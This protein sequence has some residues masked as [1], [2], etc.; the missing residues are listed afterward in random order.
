MKLW[1]IFKFLDILI[2][3]SETFLINE[4]ANKEEDIFFFTLIRVR[5]IKFLLHKLSFGEKYN[6]R[7]FKT[8]SYL[9]K[10]KGTKALDVEKY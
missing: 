2:Y 9:I 10:E 5:D 8:K 1:V 7:N 6:Q 3:E 4:I